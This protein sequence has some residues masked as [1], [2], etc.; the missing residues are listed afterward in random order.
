MPSDPIYLDS[1]DY[2]IIETALMAY[3]S[4]LMSV[5]EIPDEFRTSQRAKIATLRKRLREHR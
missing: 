3:D 5:R 2:W 4:D 1:D